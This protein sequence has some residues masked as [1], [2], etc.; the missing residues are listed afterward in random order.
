MEWDPNMHA[1]RLLLCGDRLQMNSHNSCGR[2]VREG[3]PPKQTDMKRQ[4]G[5]TNGVITHGG[6]SYTQ[7]RRP[8]RVTPGQRPDGQSPQERGRD[9][10]I[11]RHPTVDTVCVLSGCSGYESLRRGS[12]G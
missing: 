7:G 9:I 3:L 5:L 8:T 1:S 2:A 6:L 12:M 10:G 4:A 11:A